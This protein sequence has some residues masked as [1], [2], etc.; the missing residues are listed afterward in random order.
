MVALAVA[1]ERDLDCAQLVAFWCF[2]ARLR[3]DFGLHNGF[4]SA[5]ARVPQ[6]LHAPLALLQCA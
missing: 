6:L 4:V 1:P 5:L 3:V 2:F